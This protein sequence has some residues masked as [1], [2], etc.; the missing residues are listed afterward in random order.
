VA[1]DVPRL[2]AVNAYPFRTVEWRRQ[3]AAVCA[4]VYEEIGGD[5]ACTGATGERRRN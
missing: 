5:D 3:Q 2:A 1:R 4:A